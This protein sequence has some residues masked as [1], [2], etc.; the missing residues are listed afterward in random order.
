MVLALSELSGH[1]T[2]ISASRISPS[3]VTDIQS[4]PIKY[5]LHRLLQVIG[6][7]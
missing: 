1:F 2:D 6:I 3:M 7:A 4:L 5:A